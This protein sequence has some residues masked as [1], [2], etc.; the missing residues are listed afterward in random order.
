MSMS[1]CVCV[2]VPPQRKPDGSPTYWRGMNVEVSMPT[3]TLCAER[4]AIGTAL[5][6]YPQ[7][8]REDF[9]AVAVLSLS[10]A[11]PENLNPLPPCGVCSEWLEKITEANKKKC[12]ILK[13]LEAEILSLEDHL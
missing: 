4:N 11:A 3:G 10:D 8:L 9:R 1:M 5:S 2:C 7:A 6:M 13:E 12:E